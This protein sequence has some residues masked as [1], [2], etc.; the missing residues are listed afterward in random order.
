MKKIILTICLIL[1]FAFSVQAAE[2]INLTTPITKPPIT[3]YK[4]DSLVLNWSGAI[5]TITLFDPVS[6][7]KP[8]FS[9]YGTVATNLMIALNKTDLSVKSLQKRIF[10]KLIAD[11]KILGTISGVPD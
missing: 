9:Y 7:E 10:E 2:Q 11:G 4:I 5:I 6:G 8:V 1:V 3:N